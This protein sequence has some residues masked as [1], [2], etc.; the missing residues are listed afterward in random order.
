MKDLVRKLLGIRKKRRALPL[1]APPDTGAVIVRQ[2]IK[3]VVSHPINEELW[4]WM[5][6]C[7]WRVNPVKND[8]R[9]YRTLPG[10]TLDKLIRA[11]KEHRSSVHA[12]LLQ[13]APT[14]H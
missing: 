2:D 11:D 7:G 12:Q 3:T 9:R 13:S 8:R 5:M 14:R 10:G 1:S 4:D 6:L